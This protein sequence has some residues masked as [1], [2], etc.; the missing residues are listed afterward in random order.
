VYGDPAHVPV[1]E[2]A[3][4]SATNPY[5]RTKL[6]ME[7][8]I[9]ELCRADARFS[10]VL[11][12]YFN[13]VGAHPSGRMGEDPQ[14]IPGN[15]VPF[16]AQVAVG[17]RER[18]QVFGGDWPTPDG[19]GVRDYIHIMDLAEAH[20]AAL[21]HLETRMTGG[22][23][24]PINLGTGEGYSVLQVVRAFEAACGREIPYAVVDR[25]PGDVARVWADPRRAQALLGWRATRSLA[26]MCAD[27]W[28]WQHMNPAGYEPSDEDRVQDG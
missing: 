22:E 14:G 25:R 21:R 26:E 11:L 18:L 20:V 27:A 19:T 5:G 28:R 16:V 6:V 10:S 12:R 4:L 8:V 17:R 1:D 15:L 13:P 3:P 9:G 7:E 2:S 24:I 23:V